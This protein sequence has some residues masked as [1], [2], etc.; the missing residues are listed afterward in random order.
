LMAGWMDEWMKRG[1]DHVWCAV[2]PT[3]NTQRTQERT[4][5]DAHRRIAGEGALLF[6]FWAVRNRGGWGT[7]AVNTA[8]RLIL[9]D[10]R[11]CCWQEADESVYLSAKGSI[12]HECMLKYRCC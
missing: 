10:T 7:T 8:V 9:L 5:D 4:Q 2:S 3:G 11:L 6:R 12:T 1:L